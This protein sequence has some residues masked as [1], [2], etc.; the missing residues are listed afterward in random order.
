ML[1]AVTQDGGRKRKAGKKAPWWDDESHEAALFSHLNKW[2][3]GEFKDADSGTHPCVHLA[4]R[5]L[6][7]A[8][9]DMYGRLNPRVFTP[10]TFD[11]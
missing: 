11:L 10:K 6:V 1:Q 5:A 4:W 2:K 8:Y 9:Q 3:H 7:I